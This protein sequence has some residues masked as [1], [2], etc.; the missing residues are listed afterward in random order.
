M[1]LIPIPISSATEISWSKTILESLIAWYTP[2][3][4]F[5]SIGRI[6]WNKSISV[7]K[8]ENLSISFF[9]K[10]HRTHKEILQELLESIAFQIV[11]S[12]QE[13]IMKITN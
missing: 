10:I 13:T 1:N 8:L 11:I 9:E 7:A 5:F 4:S 2:Q 3:L 12:I 6:S